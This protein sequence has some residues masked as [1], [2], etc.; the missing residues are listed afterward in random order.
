MCIMCGESHVVDIMI[1]DKDSTRTFCPNCLIKG[2]Y[3]NYINF[4]NNNNL[5]DDIT[6]YDGAVA[7]VTLDE[8]YVLHRETMMRLILHNLKSYEWEALY[9][10]YVKPTG[11]F[12]YLLHSDFY[13]SSGNDLQPNT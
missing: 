4:A 8:S 9:N 1:I 3:N 6:G 13:D 2:V 12:H 5:T 11:K 7:Y 10:K